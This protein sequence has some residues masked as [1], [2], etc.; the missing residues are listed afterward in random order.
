MKGLGKM[1]YRMERV[2]R[3]WLMVVG[4]KGSI[5]ME[6]N[7]AMGSINGLIRLVIK[8]SGVGI[9]LMVLASIFGMM[10]GDITESGEIIICMDWGFIIW[11]MEINTKVNS[12]KQKN[13]ATGFIIGKMVASI[14][15]GGTM[16]NS[17][18]SGH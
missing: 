18:V 14:P 5:K 4:M 17:M 10:I 7:R 9:L 12:L 16:E 11:S 2:L 1:T 6:R 3:L 13:K 15:D 8:G